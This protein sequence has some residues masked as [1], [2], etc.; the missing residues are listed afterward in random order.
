MELQMYITIQAH[1]FPLSIENNDI[2]DIESNVLGIVEREVD[3]LK[4]YE[5]LTENQFLAI[6]RIAKKQT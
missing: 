6:M 4:A 2:I 3:L 5:M 1:H